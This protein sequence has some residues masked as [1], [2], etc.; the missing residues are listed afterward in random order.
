LKVDVR[1]I[2]A[3][4]RDIVEAIRE[5]QFREDLYHRLNVVQL[6][7]PPLRER[8]PDVILLADHFL[9]YFNRSLNRHVQGISA[10][11]RQKLQGHHWPGNVRELRNVMERAVILETE[12]EIQ[13]RSLPDFQLET[14]LRKGEVVSSAA[15]RSLDELLAEFEKEMITNTLE[16]NLHNLTKTA[17]VLKIS[18][19]ALRYRMQRLN[20]QSTAGHEDEPPVNDEKENQP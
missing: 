9:N 7:P 12:P 8:G 3:T 11:A 10:A 18:R 1:L 19:H 2:A 14:R 16:Q 20:L 6:R 13:A 17:E 5:N 15:H 4:N